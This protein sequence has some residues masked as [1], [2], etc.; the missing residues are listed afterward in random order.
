MRKR[1]RRTMVTVILTTLV[2]AYAATLFFVYWR[3]R[4]LAE[5]DLKYQSAYITTATNISGEQYLREL[6]EVE[7][8]T[9]VTL[10]S[11]KGKVLY[12]T[13]QDEYTFQNHR[14]RPEVRQALATGY[15]QNVRRSTTIG[16]DLYYVARRLD[17]GNILR[18]SKPIRNMANTAL[19]LLPIMAMI[20]IC[21]LAFALYLSGR[22]ARV[23]VQPINELDLDNPLQ[24]DVYDELHP[25]LVRI[26]EQNRA[27]DALEEMRQTF[28]A[29]VSHELKTP[30]TSISGYAEIIRDGIVRPEDIPGFSDR[31]YREANRLL[32]LINDIIRLSEL[33][34]GEVTD[35]MK[36]E[37]LCE[38]SQEIVTR[39]GAK[40]A[41][42]QVHVTFDG[43]SGP[44]LGIR[45]LLDEMI[46]NVIDNAI[47]YNREGG[48]VTVVVGRNGSESFVSVADTGIGIPKDQQDRIF[49]RFYRV[50]KSRS[51]AR[52]GTGLGLSIVK[53]GAQIHHARVDIRSTVGK[54]TVMVLK[55]PDPDTFRTELA[56]TQARPPQ[57][58]E[59][60]E[61]TKRQRQAAEQSQQ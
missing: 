8:G 55:F 40:A 32:D 18:V 42:N 52:G 19:E 4:S 23:L 16:Q 39:L 48:S 30:L 49:E 9:R 10:I 11:P 1:I 35:E 29:N 25:L 7:P 36:A 6:D 37:D 34:E 46:Y 20:G 2:I 60:E 31:I 26:D 54:G 38:L 50:D 17:D 14:N 33:D 45:R 41:E 47:K 53:H 5:Q 21:T 22:Q 12:D 59:R 28:S 3:V 43:Q 51:K 61:H 24:N 13:E 27:R 57:Q 56:R 58:I 44:V 15:G